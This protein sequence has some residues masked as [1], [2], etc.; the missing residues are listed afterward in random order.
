MWC[1]DSKSWGWFEY[2]FVRFE[3]GIEG[4]VCWVARGVDLC[5]RIGTVMMSLD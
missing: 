2:C 3:E 1:S 4:L 5:C